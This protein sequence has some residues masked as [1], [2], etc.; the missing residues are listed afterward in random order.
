[1]STQGRTE[2]TEGTE[3]EAPRAPLER[4]GARGGAD[5]LAFFYGLWAVAALSR[6]GYQYLVRRPPDLTPTHISFFVG[7]LYVLI[8]I[9]LRRRS[10]RAW[11]IALL[12]LCVELLGVVLVG[13]IDLLWRPFPY[14]SVW[15]AYG[16]GYLFMPLVLPAAGLM[17]LMQRGMRAAYG[18]GRRQSSWCRATPGG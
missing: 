8:I 7:A 17:W 5:A 12:L 15:S 10:P 14:T 2:G 9:A 16:A 3:F 18:V 4:A 13:T 6:A 11:W 1:M